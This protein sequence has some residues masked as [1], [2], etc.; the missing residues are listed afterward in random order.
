MKQK[1][2]SKLAT[3]ETY[4]RRLQEVS[5]RNTNPAGNGTGT[6]VQANGA[7]P[8]VTLPGQLPQPLFTG[9]PV[10]TCAY[11]GD[12]TAFDPSALVI[13]YPTYNEDLHLLQQKTNFI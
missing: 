7:R 10:Y 5:I 8:P 4:A 1:F 6:S 9:L 12:H 2:I 3:S 13:Y 11:V